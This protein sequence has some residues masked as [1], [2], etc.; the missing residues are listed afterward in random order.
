MRTS[1]YPSPPFYPRIR[2]LHRHPYPKLLRKP[3]IRCFSMKPPHEDPPPSPLKLFEEMRERWETKQGVFNPNIG[4]LRRMWLFAIVWD[5]MPMINPHFNAQDFL[6][7]AK[8]GFVALQ[9]SFHNRDFD[10]L[11]D[12]TSERVFEAFRATANSLDEA[13]VTVLADKDTGGYT[14]LD[15]Y[16]DKV[17]LGG[18]WNDTQVIWAKVN[19]YYNVELDMT[20]K[21]KNGET[22]DHEDSKTVAVQFE[23]CLRGEALEWRISDLP[24]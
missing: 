11:R 9:A 10:Q 1:F 13:G 16:I 2:N 5:M 15:A 21:D 4:L 17:D 6:E 19:V 7:G 24:V 8:H 20:M 3:C 18:N 14:V 23:G 22:V 12:I